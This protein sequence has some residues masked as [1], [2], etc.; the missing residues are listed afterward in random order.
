[1]KDE[2]NNLIVYLALT[3]LGLN[4]ICKEGKIFLLEGEIPLLNS[5]NIVY[6]DLARVL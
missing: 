2:K 1:M 3:L 6:L 4:S 5:S